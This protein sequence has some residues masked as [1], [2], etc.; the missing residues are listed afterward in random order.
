MKI[1]LLWFAGLLGF[2][3]PLLA[4][5]PAAAKLVIVGDSTVCNYPHDPVR[6]GW[7]MYIQGYF[8]PARLQVYN[9][10]LSGRSTSTFIK[11]GHWAVALGLKPAYVLIQFGHNDSH[12]P[13]HPEATDA[14]TTYRDYLRQYVDEARAIG[15]RPIL[16]TPMCRRIFGPDGKIVNQLL[17]YVE[18][19]KAVAAERKVPLV[20]LNSA[21]VELCNRL[22]P[23]GSLAL[24]NDP[25]DATHFCA[26]GAEE[27]AR[28]VMAQLPA[29]EPSLL[30]LEAAGAPA[31]ASD[32]HPYL[33]QESMIIDEPS[34]YWLVAV[35]PSERVERALWC[36]LT[37]DSA[38]ILRIDGESVEFMTR[39]QIAGYFSGAH[40]WP[41][42]LR[43][44]PDHGRVRDLDCFSHP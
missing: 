31:Q 12:G 36:D 38:E 23:Q 44:K 37:E 14:A 9:L 8:D 41:V 16:V 42:R 4:E 33:Y 43:V 11:E 17:P 6:R 15:A 20:D 39:K 26:K 40:G 2:T 3:T 35:P 25:K 30:P 19:M 24:A 27:M 28:L 34:D 7:G 13:G 29:V 32:L 21:S 10:A 1:G 22:G 5:G 18:A